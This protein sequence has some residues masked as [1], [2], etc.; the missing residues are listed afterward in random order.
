MSSFFYGFHSLIRRNLS[1]L[2][3]LFIAGGLA[4][5][6]YGLT[7]TLP[8]YPAYW[9]VVLVGIV[10][11]LSLWSPVAG[12]F[13][14]VLA[15][16]Y[17]LY[18]I[19]IYVAVLF[20]AVAVIGQHIFIQNLGATLLTLAS[21]LLGGVY[22]A[23]TIP[24][25]GGL[26]WGP[27]GGALMGAFA[28]LWG[29]FF[30][31]LAGLSPDWLNLLGV[32]PDLRLSGS[33]FVSANSL[34]TLRLLIAPF[35][36]NSTILLYYVL[37]IGSWAFAGW[38]VGMLSGKEWAQYHRPRATMALAAAGSPVL[39]LLH[40][41]P[42]WWLGVLIQPLAWEG[43]GFATLYSA[44]AVV[45]LEAGAYFFEHPIPLPKSPAKRF[46]DDRIFHPAP[47]PA[48]PVTLPPMDTDDESD[49]LIMLELD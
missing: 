4:A 41:L 3:R 9:D 30:A 20:L 43:L 18:T 11:L 28:A 15:T 25:L 45:I 17:P 36:S 33:Q 27:A 1:L 46:D 8:V 26:W 37:Q 5:A 38:L 10:F 47:P 7:R 19:S 22:L 13:F 12:Y 16:C 48:P 40:I 34:E 35:G 31:G 14:A 2:E 23:W 24:L 39:G 44:L 21:P 49:D 42:A 32:L 29:Q 6:L